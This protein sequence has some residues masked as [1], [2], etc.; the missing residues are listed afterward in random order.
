MIN[1]YNKTNINKFEKLVPLVGF[2]IRIMK[3]WNI[4][5]ITGQPESSVN[6]GCYIPTQDTTV[7]FTNG[8]TDNG[9][10]V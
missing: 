3:E 1:S 6:F 8:S 2:I 4:L 10:Q 7:P 9:T 5:N